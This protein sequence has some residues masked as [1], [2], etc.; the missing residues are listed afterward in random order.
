MPLRPRL[1]PPSLVHK[2]RL[3]PLDKPNF[4]ESSTQ[5]WALVFVGLGVALAVAHAFNFIRVVEPFL[6]Y[7]GYIG[8]TFIVGASGTEALRVA[9]STP[10]EPLPKPAP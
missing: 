4:C 3:H 10:P 9:K 1:P 5:K 7:F 6:T 2:P 8:S